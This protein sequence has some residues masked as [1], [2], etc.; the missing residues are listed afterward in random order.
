MN[1]QAFAAMALILFLICSCSSMTACPDSE[2]VQDQ[3]YLISIL[4][5]IINSQESFSVSIFNRKTLSH[6]LKQTELLTHS[7]YLIDLN[8]KGYYTLSFSGTDNKLYTDGIWILNK[9][10]DI[11]SYKLFKEGN[12]I[13]GVKYSFTENYLDAHQTIKNVINTVKSGAKYYYKDH[14]LSK[15]NS[16]NCNSA[17][18]ETIALKQRQ[19]E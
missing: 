11:I 8:G 1:K 10:T 17:V 15:P 6:W 5:N 18:N 4:E 14:I 3:L 2:P 7:F 13:W 16:F 12:N 9:N 19:Y